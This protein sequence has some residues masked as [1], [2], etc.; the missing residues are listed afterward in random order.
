MKRAFTTAVLAAS[1]SVAAGIASAATVTSTFNFDAA[2]SYDPTIGSSWH[3]SLDYSDNG[4]DLTVSSE[5]YNGAPVDGYVATWAGHGLGASYAG[6]SN[7]QIDG[8]GRDQ[9]VVFDFSQ[10]ATITEIVFNYVHDFDM[11]DMFADTGS[12]LNLLFSDGVTE[13]YSIS[14]GAVAS[15]FAVGA[16]TDVSAFKIRSITAEW[17]DVAPV[18][19]P[20][21][22]LLIL[23]GLGAVA[24]LK[25]RKAKA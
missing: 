4:L 18:P 20:A 21:G 9:R 6:D 7:H 22:G 15:L 11:F 13:T 17:D 10:A 5:N 25:R 2:Y 1:F 16:S 14:G 19:L 23:T 8:Y 3:S 24:A 12:G